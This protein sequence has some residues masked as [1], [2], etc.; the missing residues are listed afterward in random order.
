M[1]C[2][3]DHLRAF[4]SQPSPRAS[5]AL[6][7]I[8]CQQPAAFGGAWT[9][10]WATTDRPRQWPRRSIRR[11]TPFRVTAPGVSETTGALPPVS[12]VSPG[13]SEC[14]LVPEARV[15]RGSHSWNP[16]DNTR[17]VRGRRCG[18]LRLTESTVQ[19]GQSRWRRHR[20]AVERGWRRRGRV[21]GTLG[22]AA[23]GRS[24]HS[25]APG[26]SSAHAS[27]P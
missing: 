23:M 8:P 15:M 4:A 18:P 5:H 12:V 7:P 27:S 19:A 25:P 17:V 2:V 6:R 26:A 1:W 10:A 20:E 16:R 22:M 11:R 24:H 21:G 13:R 3:V 9:N 14:L